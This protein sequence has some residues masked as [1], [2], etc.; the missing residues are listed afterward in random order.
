MFTRGTSIFGGIPDR[1][2]GN[3]YFFHGSTTLDDQFR[4]IQLVMLLMYKYGEVL[5]FFG[6]FVGHSNL[7]VASPKKSRSKFLSSSGC[8][9]QCGEPSASPTAMVQ[10]GSRGGGCRWAVQ[11]TGPVQFEN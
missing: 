2:M 3:L 1:A 4:S 11:G 6:D 5:T 10:S 7:R 8:P 9:L